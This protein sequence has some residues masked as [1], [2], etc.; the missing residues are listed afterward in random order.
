MGY[1]ID[2]AQKSVEEDQKMQEENKNAID[3]PKPGASSVKQTADEQEAM[4]AKIAAI[5]EKTR[6]AAYAQREAEADAEIT[7]N[8]ID[9]SK[10]IDD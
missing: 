1:N 2:E 5:N 4:L 6:Q 7:A 8:L 3:L 10:P 9:F